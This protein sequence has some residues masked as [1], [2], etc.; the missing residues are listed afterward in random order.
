MKNVVGG[1][2]FTY[3]HDTDCFTEVWCRQTK[4]NVKQFMFT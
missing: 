2:H 3:G 4:N 1:Q